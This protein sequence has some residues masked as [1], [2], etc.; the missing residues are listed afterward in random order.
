MQAHTIVFKN[1]RLKLNSML[2]WLQ[3]HSSLMPS[4]LHLSL[5]HLC[6]RSKHPTFLSSPLG[7]SIAA[8]LGCHV[9]VGEAERRD[10][11]WETAGVCVCGDWGD[12]WT[13]EPETEGPAH[14][15]SESKGEERICTTASSL[16]INFSFTN[17]LPLQLIL[18]LCKGSAR[19]SVDSQAVQSYL[20]RLPITSTNADVSKWML[21]LWHQR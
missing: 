3:D 7:A 12:P 14:P 15:G 11:L 18:E 9:A 8:P 16:S 10:E 17:P 5:L 19:G 21:H 6:S 2:I 1:K 20:D 4:S 13:D